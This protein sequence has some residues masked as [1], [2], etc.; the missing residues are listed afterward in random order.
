M[1]NHTGVSGIVK[2]GSNAVAEL[3]S[4]TLDT[5]AELIED[6]TLTDSSRTYQVGKKGATVSAECWWD[7]TDTNGQIAMAEGS[8]VTLN[9]YPEGA[10]SG[11]YY[12]SGTYIMGSN[13]VSTPTD[14]II[15]ASFNATL[16]GALTRG[17][18]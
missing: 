4:F 17:T 3:R 18:V 11:D 16:T 1:A 12:Y 7:E 8:Q 5:T 9:L 6:T 10:D 15:E 14:G 13:S 2:V